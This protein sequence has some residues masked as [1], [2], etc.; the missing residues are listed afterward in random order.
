[1]CNSFCLPACRNQLAASRAVWGAYFFGVPR[2]GV[3]LEWQLLWPIEREIVGPEAN[4]ESGAGEGA[5]I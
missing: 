3:L 5:I 1:M 2:G 4:E